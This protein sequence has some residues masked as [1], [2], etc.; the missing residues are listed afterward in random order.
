MKK[1]NYKELLKEPMLILLFCLLI[2]S[3]VFIRPIP[4]M[5]DDGLYTIQTNLKKGLDLEGGVR[6]LILPAEEGNEILEKCRDVLSSRI[7]AYGLKEMTAR[8]IDIEGKGYI[9]LE[10]ADAT[11]ED[12]QNIISKQGK[13][14]AKIKKPVTIVNKTGELKLNGISYNVTFIDI[15]NIIVDGKEMDVVKNNLTMNQTYAESEDD[16]ILPQYSSNQIIIDGITFEVCNISSSEVIFYATAY[17]GEDILSTSKEAGGSRI[18]GS[19]DQWRYSF[20]VTTKKDAAEKFAKITKDIGNVIIESGANYLT[21]KIDLF[22]DDEPINSLYI[23]TSLR[24][25]IETNTIIEGPGKSKEDAVNKMKTMQAILDSGALPTP[26]TIVSSSNISPVLGKQFLHKSVFAIILAI[27]AVSIIVYLRYKNKAIILPIIFTGVSELILI[28]GFAAMIK[29]TIDLAAIAGIMAV[30]GSGIDDQI[31]LTDESA[32]KEKLSLKLKL[33]NAFF[34][35]M[36]AAATTIAAMIPLLSIAG[37][38]I[39]GFAITTIAGV[40][41]G[42]TITRPVYSKILEYIRE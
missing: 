10:I 2:L 11:E 1:I 15:E 38:V 25:R 33:K 22:L 17:K 18:S 19:K 20:R 26:I 5:G 36:T 12:L 3:L 29:W 4:V 42:I 34:I 24:G 23:S 8:I 21:S 30:I 7:N 6:A 28:L 27:F 13:F 32:K 35:I 39:R 40:I 9:Q 41:I 31:V 16:L 37:G 14:E